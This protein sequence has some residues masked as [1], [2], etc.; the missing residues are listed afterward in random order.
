MTGRSAGPEMAL[1]LS[2]TRGERRQPQFAVSVVPLSCCVLAPLA[3]RAARVL[4][5]SNATGAMR[6]VSRLVQSGS[7]TKEYDYRRTARQ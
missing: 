7:M 6:P 5:D 4:V 2:R 1:W 3:M